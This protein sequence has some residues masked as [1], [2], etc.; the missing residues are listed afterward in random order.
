MAQRVNDP[1][2]LRGLAGSI[3][4]PVQWVKDPGVAAAVV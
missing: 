1:A 3:P 4:C 2:C